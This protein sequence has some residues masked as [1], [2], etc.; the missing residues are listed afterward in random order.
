MKL[1]SSI[2]NPQDLRKLQRSDLNELAREL[3]EFIISIV[4]EHGGHL[5]ASLG[6]VELTV[7]LHYC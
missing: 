2:D 6:T 4:A 3:R 7:A 5:G 1:L